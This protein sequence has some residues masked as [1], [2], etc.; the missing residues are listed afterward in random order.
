M[1][2]IKAKDVVIPIVYPD[3]KIAVGGRHLPYLGHA[4][5]LL[6]NGKSGGTH[7]YEYG[8]YAP[9]PGVKDN[10][11]GRVRDYVPAKV[12]LGRDGHA[13]R[14]TL[15]RVLAQVAQYACP[16]KPAYRRIEAAYVCLPGA[17]GKMKSYTDR[18]KAQNNDPNRMSYWVLFNNCMTLAQQT[19]LVGG[20]AFATSGPAPTDWIEDVRDLY[21]DLDYDPKSGRVTIEHAWQIGDAKKSGLLPTWATEKGFFRHR[22]G[23][24]FLTRT[25]SCEGGMPH[26]ASSLRV[27]PLKDRPIRA[28]RLDILE[29][30]GVEVVA[31]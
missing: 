5:V 24:W 9:P 4:G 6:I 29:Q 26:R 2:S 1:M 20:A 27:H 16:T 23:R 12:K 30:R 25:L 11:S 15:Q 31:T 13:T 17:W 7:Y 22:L 10:V 19:M 14:H 8:R 3:Y 21:P 18:R 28:D